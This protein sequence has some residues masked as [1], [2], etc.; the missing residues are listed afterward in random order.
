M[1][2]VLI[3][4]SISALAFILSILYMFANKDAQSPFPQNTPPTGNMNISG[5]AIALELLKSSYKQTEEIN[6]LKAKIE[7]LES[8][9]NTLTPKPPAPDQGDTST[10]EI[11]PVSAKFLSRIMPTVE[12]SLKQNQ[13]IF[14]LQLFDNSTAYSTY[15]DDKFGMTVVAS[16]T[17]Y[18]IFLK[19]FQAIDKNVYTV[20]PTSTFPFEGFYVNP[21]KSDATVRLVLAVEAQTLL[22]S[23]PKSK[24]DTFKSLIL[25]PKK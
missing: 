8:G 23:L 19:N 2:I 25:N 3:I 16:M 9:S 13:G 18:A 7:A 1:R 24:F 11:I 15:A 6:A 5:D 17:P 21:A 12:L 10:G 22:I 14:D 4:L 20:N